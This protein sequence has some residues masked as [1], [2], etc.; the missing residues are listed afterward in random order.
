MP[1]TLYS[2]KNIR[3]YIESIRSKKK[4]NASVRFAF[5]KI[6]FKRWAFH[7]YRLLL[8]SRRVNRCVRSFSPPLVFLNP[9]HTRGGNRYRLASFHR[10]IEGVYNGLL[11]FW[12]KSVLWKYSCDVEYVENLKNVEIPFI[13]SFASTKQT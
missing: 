4:T 13:T 6:I 9:I 7:F 12:I 2:Y 3:V 11:I 8:L 5:Q 1:L 10:K